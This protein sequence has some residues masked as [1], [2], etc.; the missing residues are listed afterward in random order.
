MF[1]DIY[2]PRPV[3]LMNLLE[4]FVDGIFLQL[5]VEWYGILIFGLV[6]ILLRARKIFEDFK[7]RR[8]SVFNE[9]GDISSVG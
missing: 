5:R 8:R 7:F 9:G 1:L 6:G 2:N 3:P 4:N